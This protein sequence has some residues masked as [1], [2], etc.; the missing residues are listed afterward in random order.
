M[1]IVVIAIGISLLCGTIAVSVNPKISKENK[2][3]LHSLDDG[4][5][6]IYELVKKERMKIYA[7][8]TMLGIVVSIFVLFMTKLRNA[9]Y[10]G[11]AVMTISLG[12]QYF[13]YTLS[14]KKYSMV[15]I[16]DNETQ[17]REW[18]EV[19]REY[20]WS[21]HMGIVVGLVATFALG[22]GL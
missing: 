6:T 7:W 20:Q 16:L 21:Y 19:Y 2:E 11:F 22:Y 18:N 10:R 8:G 14:P 13:F 17:R 5:K 15:E 3:F 12:I 4:Q 1:N 9:F